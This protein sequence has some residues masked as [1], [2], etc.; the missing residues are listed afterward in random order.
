[1]L[2]IRFPSSS[3]LAR[4]RV[5]VSSGI[6]RVQG[7]VMVPFVGWWVGLRVVEVDERHEIPQTFP[8][9]LLRV[10][11][12]GKRCISSTPSTHGRSVKS[13]TPLQ[14]FAP[15]VPSPSTHPRSRNRLASTRLL[16]A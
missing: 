2:K 14:I 12:W 10:E 11:F 16:S 7:R 13:R 15:R 1:M 9:N 3:N 6:S 5:A 4:S 8:S